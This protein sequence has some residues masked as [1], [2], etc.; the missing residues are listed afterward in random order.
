MQKEE[1][2]AECGSEIERKK[3]IAVSQSHSTSHMFMPLLPLRFSS[4]FSNFFIHFFCL[5]VNKERP[6]VLEKLKEF[7]AYRFS[8]LLTASFES[9]SII[10]DLDVSFLPCLFPP[11]KKCTLTPFFKT[12]PTPDSGDL[13]ISQIFE[14]TAK[15][16]AAFSHS[17]SF[18]LQNQKSNKKVFKVRSFYLEHKFFRCSFK[19][20]GAT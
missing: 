12:L 20:F 1:L 7:T 2:C 18:F 3:L 10:L 11:A 13:E 5:Q 17:V 16:Y 14:Q 9:W 4:A 15:S 19:N 8:K 6:E